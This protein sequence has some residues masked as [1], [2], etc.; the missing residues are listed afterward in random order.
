MSQIRN[1]IILRPVMGQNRRTAVHIAADRAQTGITA[2]AHQ[3]LA[4]AQAIITRCQ[5]FAAYRG[6]SP[7]YRQERPLVLDQR[8]LVYQ[9][10]VIAPRLKLTLLVAAATPAASPSPGTGHLAWQLLR[11]PAA[12]PA[13]ERLVYRLQQREQFERTAVTHTIHQLNARAQRLESVATPGQLQAQVTSTRR[14][15]AWPTADP[16]PPVPRVRAVP[17]VLHRPDARPAAPEQETPTAVAAHH[18]AFPPTTAWSPAAASSPSL[19]AAAI[20]VN[21]LTDQ[22]MRNI[23]HRIVAY[24]ERTGRM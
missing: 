14:P 13:S 21:H 2:V 4:L 1:P 7:V 17:R 8:S 16:P 3:S 19:P 18:P 9:R 20:D 22:I 12:A 5:L 23:D 6:L 15:G 10:E 11:P 24:R